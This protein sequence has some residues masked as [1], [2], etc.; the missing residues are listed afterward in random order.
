M[1]YIPAVGGRLRRPAA[2]RSSRCR[3]CNEPIELLFELFFRGGTGRLHERTQPH[4][5]VNAQS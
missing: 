4:I 1:T 3:S 5:T 2:R